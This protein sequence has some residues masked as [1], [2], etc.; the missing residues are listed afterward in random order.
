MSQ[1]RA[2]VSSQVEELTAEVHTAHQAREASE[3]MLA[4]SEHHLKLSRGTVEAQSEQ[5]AQLAATQTCYGQS[6]KPMLPN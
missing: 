2:Q 4:E 3:A 6:Q 5:R 1:E